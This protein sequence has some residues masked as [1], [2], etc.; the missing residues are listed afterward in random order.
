MSHGELLPAPKTKTLESIRDVIAGMPLAF[1]A[2]EAGDLVATIEFDV[3]DEE[4][5][6]YHVII[7]KG[8]CKAYAG[9]HPTPTATK[10]TPA[11]VWLKIVRGELDATNAFMSQQF[12]T[13][14]DMGLLMKMTALFGARS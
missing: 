3:T 5:G 13:S 6:D 10:H 4:P 7:E 9:V 14:G 1:N 11:D 8:V 12:T 2:A